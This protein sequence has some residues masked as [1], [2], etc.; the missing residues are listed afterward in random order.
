MSIGNTA[1]LRTTSVCDWGVCLLHL[2]RAP[3]SITLLRVIYR[4]RLWLLCMRGLL[5][6]SLL[7]RLCVLCLLVPCGLGLMCRGLGLTLLLCR[8]VLLLRGFGLLLLPVLLL[9]LLLPRIRG[10]SGSKKHKQYCGSDWEFH[11]VTSH[12]EY[13]HSVVIQNPAVCVERN[14]SRDAPNLPSRLSQGRYQD[15][16]SDSWSACVAS[17]NTGG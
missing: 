4:M 12:F 9:A 7:C 16:F 17:A 13:I 2:C 6:A 11:G 8:P 1:V 14:R 3:S 5:R 15:V 10:N